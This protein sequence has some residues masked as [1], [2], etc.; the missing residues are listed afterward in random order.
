M[1]LNADELKRR[2]APFFEENFTRYGELGAAVS[3][4]QDEKPIVNLYGGFRD[5]QREQLWLYLHL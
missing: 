4:W 2:L 5:A 1:Q 3:I